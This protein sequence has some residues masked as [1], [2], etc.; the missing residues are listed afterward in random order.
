MS[1]VPGDGGSSLRA[2]PGAGGPGSGDEPRRLTGPGWWDPD[3]RRH[4]R[5][6]PRF[7]P[8]CGAS[9][10]SGEGISVEFWEGDARLYHTWCRSCDW[11]GDIIRTD[12]MWGHEPAD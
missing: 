10:S 6:L 3:R 12:R 9:L 1:G 11:T 8:A 2:A 5:D 4:R 7:C